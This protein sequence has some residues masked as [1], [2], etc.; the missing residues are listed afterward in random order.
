MAG[1]RTARINE[2]IMKEMFEILRI[3]KEGNL[4]KSSSSPKSSEQ[5]GT[6]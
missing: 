6:I 2:E 3:I 1:N 5:T 4:K